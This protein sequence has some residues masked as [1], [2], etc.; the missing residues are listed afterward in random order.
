MKPAS[1]HG[2]ILLELHSSR[3]SSVSLLFWQRLVL[4]EAR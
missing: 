3:L 2:D 4:L 1:F